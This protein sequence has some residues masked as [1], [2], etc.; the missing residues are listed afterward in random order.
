M[1]STFPTKPIPHSPRLRQSRQ[2]HRSAVIYEPNL[3]DLPVRPQPV[4]TQPERPVPVVQLPGLPPRS[5]PK[6]VVKSGPKNWS[7]VSKKCVS[8]ESFS[9]LSM[10]LTFLSQKAGWPSYF[11]LRKFKKLYGPYIRQGQRHPS[12]QINTTGV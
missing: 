1:F 3:N 8:I 7:E 4:W 10:E 2:A 5:I 9:W 11:L 12:T 6:D